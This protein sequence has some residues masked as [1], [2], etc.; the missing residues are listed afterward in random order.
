MCVATEKI[1]AHFFILRSFLRMCRGEI[2]CGCKFFRKHIP[3]FADATR[4]C[5][6]VVFEVFAGAASGG[7]L[8]V[9]RTPTKRK[10]FK[11]LLEKDVLGIL[12]DVG[13][14]IKD[15]C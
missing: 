14:G 7:A 6:D 15:T 5:S 11:R 12:V 13:Q 1:E 3:R 9:L 8:G 10:M 4:S 2:R